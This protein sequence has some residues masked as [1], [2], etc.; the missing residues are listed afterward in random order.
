MQKKCILSFIFVFITGLSHANNQWFWQLGLGIGADQSAQFKD[1][2]CNHIA[3]PALFGCGY[4]AKG[5]LQDTKSTEIGIGYH[6]NRYANI[7]LIL[8]SQTMDFQ[9]QANF[10]NAGNQQPVNTTLASIGYHL[11][12]EFNLLGFMEIQPNVKP[13]IDIG[14]GI[15]EVSTD[16]VEFGFPALEKNKPAITRISGSTE[17]NSVMSIG[18]S[19]NWSFSKSH[20]LQAGYRYYDLGWIR[21]EPGIAYVYGHGCGVANGEVNALGCNLFVDAIKSKVSSQVFSI[22]YKRFF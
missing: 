20:S 6:I 14:L 18:L 16:S 22:A 17:L 19:I 5:D 12:A 10:S 7:G 8:N 4:S 9:G 13:M 15:A 21:T 2:H 3:P 1:D 11:R